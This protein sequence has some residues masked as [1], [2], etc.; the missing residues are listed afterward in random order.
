ML[1]IIRDLNQFRLFTYFEI[2]ILIKPDKVPWAG[3]K[4]LTN[5]VSIGLSNALNVIVKYLQ[6]HSCFILNIRMGRLHQ[7]TK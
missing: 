4:C 6:E 7:S 3:N 5:V 1:A 2:R